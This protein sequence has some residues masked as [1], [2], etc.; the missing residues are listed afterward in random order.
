MKIIEK[1]SDNYIKNINKKYILN[2]ELTKK[3][4]KTTS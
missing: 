1:F 4:K 3:K 2:L